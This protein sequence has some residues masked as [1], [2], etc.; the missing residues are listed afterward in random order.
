M[1]CFYLGL[2]NVEVRHEVKRL[3]VIYLSFE[4]QHNNNSIP[5]FSSASRR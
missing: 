1:Y 3:L 5:Q 4:G 2:E